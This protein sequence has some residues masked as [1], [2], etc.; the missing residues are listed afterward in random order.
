MVDIKEE[1]EKA[2]KWAK[3][4]GYTLPILH[5]TNGKVAVSYAP[6]EV[7]PKLP[8]DEVMVAA[9]LIIDSEGLIQ[10]F[11]LLDTRNFDAKLVRLRK[12]LDALRAAE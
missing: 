5:D 9:N 1:K 10:F 7:L 12:R 11:D 4:M 2:A 6:K 3:K 8:R